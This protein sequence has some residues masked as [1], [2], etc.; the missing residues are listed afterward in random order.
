MWV[1]DYKT[2]AHEGGG[3]DAFLD[4]QRERY[5]AQLNAYANAVGGAK[6]GLYFP[7]QMSWRM[8]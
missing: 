8:W 6:P 7:L 5:V 3:L 2:S 4:E 1:V